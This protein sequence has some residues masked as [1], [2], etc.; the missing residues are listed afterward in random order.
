MEITPGGEWAP[1]KNLYPSLP[2]DPFLAPRG[3]VERLENDTLLVVIGDHGMTKSGDHGGDS[4]LE[5]SAA[6]FLYSPTALFLR[7]PPEVRA[8]LCFGFQVFNPCH[9]NSL[10]FRPQIDD[11]LA[12]PILISYLHPYVSHPRH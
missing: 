10:Y 11:L 7:A 8:E 5:V 6:L 9:D 12:S 2:P 4:E 3:I 1:E